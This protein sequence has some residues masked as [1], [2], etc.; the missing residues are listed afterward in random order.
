MKEFL[1]KP[2]FLV[3][4]GTLGADLSYLLAVVFTVLFLVAWGMAKKARAPATTNSFWSP[5]F[6]W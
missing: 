1:A 4:S 2:G 3:H 6:P 5:W